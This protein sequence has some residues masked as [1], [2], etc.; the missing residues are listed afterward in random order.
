MAAAV[1]AGDRALLEIEVD[2]RQCRRRGRELAPVLGEGA[3]G[4]RVHEIGSE[5]RQRPQ[6]EGVLQHVGARQL[7]RLAH[8]QPVVEQEVDVERA[9]AEAPA[10]TLAP[11]EP[12]NGVDV[13]EQPGG[14]PPG[15]DARDEVQ[16]VRS[17]EADRRTPVDTR[18]RD[19]AVAA[20]ELGRG[21]PEV[22]LGLDV[23]A[24]AEKNRRHGARSA[25]VLR[26]R[27]PTSRAP[28]IAPGLLTVI[29]IHGTSN[30]RS[31]ISAIRC[32]RVSTSWKLDSAT[33]SCTL[34]ATA[35]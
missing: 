17:V 20:P 33:N 19:V 21:E 29:R 22:S 6:H 5:L 8:D 16:E 24:D 12:V 32:A 15:L 30:S 9:R 2:R 26:M 23:A 27:T 14:R 4:E 35:L 18:E 13:G 10:A 25:R 31:T 28:R 11:G 3:A 34:L 7:E 1:S